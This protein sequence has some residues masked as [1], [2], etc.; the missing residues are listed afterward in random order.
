MNTDKAR[1]MTTT[2]GHSI[3]N[4]HLQYSCIVGQDLKEVISLYS[5]NN[6]EMYEETNGLR[7]LGSPTFQQD[8]IT[9]YLQKLETDATNLLEGFDDD[10]TIIQLY[11]Q[12]TSQRLNHL[13]PVDVYAFMPKLLLALVTLG[14]AGTATLPKHSITSTHT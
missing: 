8:F 4:A 9:D 1:I 11:R 14:T 6:S 10:Q 7:I 3:L 12:C 5:A 2:S 13:F